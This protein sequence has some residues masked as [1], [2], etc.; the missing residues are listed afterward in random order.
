M[1]ELT[2]IQWAVLALAA[3]I[4]GVSKTGF[5]GVGILAI[6]LAAMVFRAKPSTGM[7]LPMLIVGDLMAVAYY[8]R[9]AEWKYLVK[10]VPCAMAGIIVGHRLL[11]VVNDRQL[12][13]LIGGVILVMLALSWWRNWRMARS[14]EVH[15]PQGWWFPIV[16][17]LIG[18]ITTMMANAAGPIMVIYLVAMRLPKQT[19]IGTGAWYFLLLNV[20]KIPF[21]QNLGLITAESVSINLLLAP[22]II[23]GGLVGV[24]LVKFV[25]EKSFT[26]I[27]QL[28][29]AAGALQLVASVWLGK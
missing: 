16:I 17:G 12:K 14:G 25:P 9:H 20:F 13:P 28:L 24:R 2:A 10:L 27:V 22:V 26:W 11:A 19:F 23:L 15:V 3:V 6:P 1:G 29:A 8:R 4:I 21:S 5:T 7:I 18:G